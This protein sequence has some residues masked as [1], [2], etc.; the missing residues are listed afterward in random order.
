M[1]LCKRKMYIKIRDVFRFNILNFYLV[2]ILFSKKAKYENVYLAK[3]NII[4]FFD[5]T[6]KISSTTLLISEIS[7]Y[8][9]S[10]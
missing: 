9:I 8:K 5:S 7:L 3:Y 1:A 4:S 10:I 6:Y 2:A